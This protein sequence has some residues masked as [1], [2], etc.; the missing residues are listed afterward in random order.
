MG[1]LKVRKV[2]DYVGDRQGTPWGGFEL[3]GAYDYPEPIFGGWPV[4]VTPVDASGASTGPAVETTSLQELSPTDG[5]Y[6]ELPAGRYRVQE[7]SPSSTLGGGLWSLTGANLTQRGAT[8]PQG[9]TSSVVV[10]VVAGT[11]HATASVVRF[12]N[13][14]RV[15][16]AVQVFPV[17]G[18]ADVTAHPWACR[19]SFGSGPP[20]AEA[21]TVAGRAYDATSRLPVPEALVRA[22]DSVTGGVVAETTTDGNGNYSLTL[23]AG[24]YTLTYSRNGYR[25]LNYY[26]VVLAASEAR[27]LEV[28]YI[29][30]DRPDTLSPA[31]GTVTNA[32]TGAGV[33]GAGLALRPGINQTSGAAVATTTSGS[34]GGYSF[35]GLAPGVY[36]AEVSRGGFV[37]ARFTLVVVGAAPNANQNFALSPGP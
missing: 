4:R 11:D 12:F 30:R 27:S 7:L 14:C 1:T 19:P 28:V 25:P 21:A 15:E 23:T 36:T 8:V 3:N 29:V 6:L 17:A 32:L 5:R 22:V 10:E 9:A 35:A 37:T 34:G 31:S 33:E 18:M 20:P 2:Y 24:S 13:V 26:D 16:G